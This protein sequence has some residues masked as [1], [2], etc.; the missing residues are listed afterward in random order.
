MQ[1]FAP[2][3]PLF[4]FHGDPPIIESS[5]LFFSLLRR[6]SP[7]LLTPRSVPLCSFSCPPNQVLVRPPLPPP[8]LVSWIGDQFQDLYGG[9]GLL[10]A[11][12]P[13]S[14]SPDCGQ[15]NSRRAWCRAGGRCFPFPVFPPFFFFI[16]YL[17][18]TRLGAGPPCRSSRCFPL[19]ERTILDVNPAFKDFPRI[20]VTVHGSPFSPFLFSP[21]PFPDFFLHAGILPQGQPPDPR[22]LPGILVLFCTVF[23]SLP[24]RFLF[25]FFPYTPQQTGRGTGFVAVWRVPSS[26]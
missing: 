11:R 3:S 10:K 19:G 15:S 6:L 17:N 12:D 1:S 24:F 9:A 18:E 4:S 20:F 23:F 13:G 14:F 8:N 26:P 7:P 2:Q 25:C 16:L 21:F 22:P 5:L